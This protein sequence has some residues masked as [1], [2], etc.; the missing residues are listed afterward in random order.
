M[1]FTSLS[2][3][4]LFLAMHYPFR[5]IHL[6]KS[7]STS[8]LLTAAYCL[9]GHWPSALSGPYCHSWPRSV[10][11]GLVFTDMSARAQASWLL[12][13]CVWPMGGTKRRL[14]AGRKRGQV[15]RLPPYRLSTCSLSFSMP[16]WEW[17][18]RS[19]PLRLW[20][21]SAGSPPLHGSGLTR[22]QLQHSLPLSFGRRG[23]KDFPYLMA[24]G[25]LTYCPCLS[26]NLIHHCKQYLW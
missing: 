18:S 3:S 7:F 23:D 6:I 15:D 10:S 25:L 20:P 5:F 12:S 22:L 13:G 19:I 21:A 8:W 17:S 26:L 2:V 4:Y 11:P 14:R 24:A 16:Y 9:S 1:C